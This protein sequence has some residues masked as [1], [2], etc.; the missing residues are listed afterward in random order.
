ME[1]LVPSPEVIKM[2]HD[3]VIDISGGREGVLNPDT[4]EGFPHRPQTYMGYSGDNDLHTVCAVLI[5]S[6]SRNHGFNDGNKRTSLMSA[7]FTYTVNGVYL[8]MSLFMNK[9]YEELVLWVVLKKPSIDEIASRLKELAEKYQK[10]G[11]EAIIERMKNS[12]FPTV[13]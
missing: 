1:L 7:L 11:F 3:V 4:V 9:D 12:F 5:D 2:L 10:T 13:S 8:E 6:I